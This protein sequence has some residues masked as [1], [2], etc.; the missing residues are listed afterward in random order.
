[1]PACR[2]CPETRHGS[3][4]DCVPSD[5]LHHASGPAGHQA[6]EP[7]RRIVERNKMSTLQPSADTIHSIAHEIGFDLVRF[8]P[9]DPGDHRD[10]F[11]E[12]LDAGRHGEMDY[13]Q[14][15]RDRIVD[16]QR[17]R[18]GVRSSISV[19]VDYSGPPGELAGGG[20]IAR[21]AVGRDYHRWL[22][23]RITKLRDQLEHAGLPRG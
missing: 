7:L 18:A 13:L 5:R 6:R 14:K 23:K 11:T 22:G 20:R 2:H 1:M 4:T 19:A 15:N 10:R 17:W 12:W 9:A 21:Y 8:G 3:D 16:P